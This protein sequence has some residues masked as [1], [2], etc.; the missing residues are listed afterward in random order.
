MPIHPGPH[1]NATLSRIV[2]RLPLLAG[3]HV[4]YRQLGINPL[5]LLP[6]GR[7]YFAYSGSLTQPPCSEPVSWILLAE[8]VELEPELLARLARATGANARPVQPLN[9]RPVYAYPH[10]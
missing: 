8:P 6:S 5:F 2:E 10:P 3:E 9:G 4:Y 1:G 7:S